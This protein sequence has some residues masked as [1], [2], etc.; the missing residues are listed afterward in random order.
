MG[1]VALARGVGKEGLDRLAEQLVARVP[2][3]GLGSAVHLDDPAL[4]VHD[5]DPVGHRPQDRFEPRIAV[6]ADI[7]RA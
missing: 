7:G 6:T 5:D 3:Q 4:G 1:A 2:E